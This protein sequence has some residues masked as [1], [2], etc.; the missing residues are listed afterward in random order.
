MRRVP[1]RVQWARIL[2]NAFQKNLRRRSRSESESAGRTAGR[3]A[4]RLE[5]LRGSAWLEKLKVACCPPGRPTRGPGLRLRGPLTRRAWAAPG[6]RPAS[7]C[8]LGHYRGDCDRDAGCAWLLGRRSGTNYNT[9]CSTSGY[10]MYLSFELAAGC[11]RDASRYRI[12][13][14]R[15]GRRRASHDSC[16]TCCSQP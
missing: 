4:V 13:T 3:R 10:E 12:S 15:L 8:Q 11:D 1:L 5:G 9:T 6:A 14:S 7:G 2:K 16:C